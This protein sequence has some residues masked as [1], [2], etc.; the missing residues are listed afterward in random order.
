MVV[1]RHLYPLERLKELDSLAN[2]AMT[3]TPPLLSQR[4][5]L[6][7]VENLQMY[8]RKAERSER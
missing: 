7:R 4:K 8:F 6:L 3:K 2:E 1:G 5:A